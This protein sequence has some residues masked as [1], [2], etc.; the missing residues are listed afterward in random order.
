MRSTQNRRTGIDCGMKRVEIGGG[1]P[2]SLFPLFSLSFSTC[3]VFFQNRKS[4]CFINPFL[5]SSIPVSILN[6]AGYALDR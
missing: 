4:C 3:V 5:A 2:K 1:M 6:N